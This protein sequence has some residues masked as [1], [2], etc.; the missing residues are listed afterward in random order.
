MDAPASGLDAPA[1]EADAP[2]PELDTPASS[3]METAAG[4]DREP[5]EAA[6]DAAPADAGSPATGDAG[7][8]RLD[9]WDPAFARRL[10]LEVVTAEGVPLA[11]GQWVSL[12]FDH[13]ALVNAGAQP[14][15]GDVRI[16]RR[17][18]DGWSTRPFFLDEDSG[19]G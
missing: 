14:G 2:A 7:S 12:T 1:P 6:P 9:W 3:E 10:G 8:E 15:G 17:N 13:L 18:A 11:A 5:A 16:V 19:W 4:A